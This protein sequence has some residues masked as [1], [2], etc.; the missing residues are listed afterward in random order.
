MTRQRR[1]QLARKAEG[2]CEVCGKGPL[3]TSVK[4]KYCAE[5][6]TDLQRKRLGFEPWHPGGPGRP[7]IERV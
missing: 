3:L 1:W 7:P 6:K 4:C 2:V 5:K